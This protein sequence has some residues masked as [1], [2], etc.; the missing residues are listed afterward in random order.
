MPTASA[1]I[2]RLQCV[3]LGGVSCTVFAITF[4]RT[5]LG[6]GGTREGRV[7]VALEP[8]HAFIEIPLLPPPDRRLRHAR[9]PHDLNRPCIIGR[10]KDDA[11][12][13]SEFARRVAVGAQSFKLSAVGGAKVKADVG[14]SHSPTMSRQSKIGNP[15]SG[16][17]H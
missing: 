4:N 3:A 8:R 13:P 10:R 11:R 7:F 16:V 17:E 1:I 5:S 15:T 6:S 12:A 9:P 2:V 14:A